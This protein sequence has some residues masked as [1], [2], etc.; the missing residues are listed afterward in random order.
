MIKQ[1][2]RTKG[3]LEAQDPVTAATIAAVR[4]WLEAYIACDLDAVM[5]AVTEDCIVDLPHPAPDGKRVEGHDAVRAHWEKVFRSFPAEFETEE[6]F[7]VGDRCVFRWVRHWVGEEGTPRHIRGIDVL[8]VRDGK[9]AEK[10]V[11]GKAN[12]AEWGG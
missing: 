1:R 3:A 7:A 11:Y 4:R 10:L 6:M 9:L 12:P 5:A 8:R 2:E